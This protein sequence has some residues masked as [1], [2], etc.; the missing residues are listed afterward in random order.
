MRWRIGVARLRPPTGRSHHYA[1]HISDKEF[2]AILGRV[3]AKGIPYGSNPFNHA[4]GR[5]NR[6]RGGRGFYFEDPYGHLLEVMTV[7]RRE[8]VTTDNTIGP[9]TLTTTKEPTMSFAAEDI[10]ANRDYF[11][12]KLRAEKQK[13]DVIK[14]VKGEPGASE[15]LL[16]DTRSRDAFAK[17]H[18]PGAFSA[19]LGGAGRCAAAPQDRERVTDCWS[20][21]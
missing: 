4:N 20:D 14:R 13:N 3:K 6:R 9:R 5:I 15:F 17:A 8:R 18:I 1:F 16:L 2:D 10:R 12:N 11:V 7:P 21:T 19:P